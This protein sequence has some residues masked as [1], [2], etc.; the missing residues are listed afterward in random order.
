MKEDDELRELKKKK[1]EMVKSILEL[2]DKLMHQ[3][4]NK[5]KKSIP[6]DV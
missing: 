5:E 2:K 6:D 4:V 1:E 3:S